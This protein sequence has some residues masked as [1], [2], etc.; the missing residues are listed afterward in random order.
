M[1]LKALGMAHLRRDDLDSAGECL[2]QAL[3]IR[4]AVPDAYE[5]A[6]IYAA[7]V[8]LTRRTGQDAIA[9]EYRHRAVLLYQQANAT[10]EAEALGAA[11]T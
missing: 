11:L 3:A 5:E 4:T 2:R 10:S 1:C 8:E 6:A 9:A 7:L